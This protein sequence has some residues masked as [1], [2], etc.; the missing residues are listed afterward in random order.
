MFFNK[1]SDE[2]VSFNGVLINKRFALN[3]QRRI[4]L[5]EIDNIN[6]GT[7]NDREM[8]AEIMR[9]IEEELKCY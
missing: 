9:I 7:L 8:V 5:K 4:L 1:I 6:K 3:I 2:K